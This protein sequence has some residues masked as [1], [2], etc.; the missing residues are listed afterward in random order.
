LLNSGLFSKSN[1]PQ[2]PQNIIFRSINE[3]IKTNITCFLCSAI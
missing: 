1:L 2:L 3:I